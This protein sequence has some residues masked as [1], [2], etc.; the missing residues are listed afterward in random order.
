MEKDA[1]DCVIGGLQNYAKSRSGISEK[2]GTDTS[3]HW[4]TIMAPRSANGLLGCSRMA[5]PP[6]LCRHRRNNGYERAKQVFIDC[7]V[8][9]RVKAHGAQVLMIDG[10]GAIVAAKRGCATAARCRLE[11]RI[12]F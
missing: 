5:P 3:I 12:A 7:N 8:P 4:S 6:W 10:C 9:H 1:D 11:T 2:T